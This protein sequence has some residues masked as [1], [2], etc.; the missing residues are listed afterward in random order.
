M[1]SLEE[2]VDTHVLEVVDHDLVAIYRYHR[3]GAS[4]GK[5]PK[6]DEHITSPHLDKKDFRDAF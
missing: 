4:G 1:I 6:G 3:T 5:C 2:E